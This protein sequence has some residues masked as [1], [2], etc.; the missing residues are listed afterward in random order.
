[1][2]IYDLA[3]QIKSS[4]NLF[5]KKTILFYSIYILGTFFY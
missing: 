1:M 5:K 2:L 3:V 4:Q